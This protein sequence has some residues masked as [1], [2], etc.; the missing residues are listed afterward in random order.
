[1]EKNCVK[2]V[3]HV[4]VVEI[5]PF[6]GKNSQSRFSWVWAH[7]VIAMVRLVQIHVV[8]DASIVVGKDLLSC[9]KLSLVTLSAAESLKPLKC[10]KVS[11]KEPN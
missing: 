6:I 3:L 10:S 9:L 7:L 1:M 8:E 2:V 4:S 11:F 5:T